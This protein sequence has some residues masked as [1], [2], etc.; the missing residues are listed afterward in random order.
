M[1]EEQILP[2][3]TYHMCTVDCCALPRKNSSQ[4]N[5]YVVLDSVQHSLAPTDCIQVIHDGNTRSIP[6]SAFVNHKASISPSKSAHHWGK[7]HIPQLRRLGGPPDSPLAY[8][9]RHHVDQ[10]PHPGQQ[11]HETICSPKPA[12]NSVLL[13]LSPLQAVLRN[14]G[15]AMSL[16]EILRRRRELHRG[17]RHGEHGP[18]GC[19]VF[20]RSRGLGLG[21]SVG[22]DWRTW[23]GVA[24]AKKQFQPRK[25]VMW[26]SEQQYKQRS[27][28]YRNIGIANQESD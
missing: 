12:A 10:Q 9:V 24:D 28:G 26:R 7:V 5:T 3:Q 17:R 16:P 4:H 18:N 27:L 13:T 6:I 14:S 8:H 15:H 2:E 21:S 25:A 11:R 19:L 1:I 22:I 23:D 20:Q